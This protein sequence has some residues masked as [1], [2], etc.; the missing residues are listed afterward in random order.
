[1]ETQQVI[2]KEPKK[3]D[4]PAFWQMTIESSLERLIPPGTTADEVIAK[5][6]LD[7]ATDAAEKRGG[8]VNIV[9]DNNTFM[10]SNTGGE[11]TAS[12][13]KKITNFEACLS[14]KY[15]KKSYMRG[16]I[17]HG[18]KIAIMLAGGA[19]VES[20]GWRYTLTIKNRQTHDAKSVLDIQK[21]SIQ[22][23]GTTTF[24]VAIQSDIQSYILKHI[25]LNPH[26]SYF[27][28]DAEYHSV[29]NLNKSPKL[30]ILSYKEDTFNELTNTY[31]N[32]YDLPVFLNMFNLKQSKIAN[33]CKIKQDRFCEN[34]EIY[35]FIENNSKPIIPPVIGLEGITERLNQLSGDVSV[36]NYKKL[37]LD[38]GIVE[39][40][41]LSKP[42]H[43][44][45]INGAAVSSES[46]WLEKQ[47]S[48][49]STFLSLHHALSDFKK[50]T[51]GIYFSLMTT[52]PNFRD[53][54]KQVIQIED[55][56]LYTALSRLIK[57]N[58]SKKSNWLLKEERYKEIAASEGLTEKKLKEERGFNITPVSFLFMYECKRIAEAYREKWG[59]MTKRGLMYQLIKR[60]IIIDS[61]AYDQMLNHVTNG[62]R[63]GFIPP[64]LFEDRSRAVIFPETVSTDIRPED[65][66]QEVIQ[67]ALPPPVIDIWK[68]QEYHVELWIEK[69]ALINI[70]LPICKEK[71]VA[72]FPVRGFISGNNEHILAAE[73]RFIKAVGHEGKFPVIIYAGDLDPS[74]WEMYEKIKERFKERIF[75]KRVRVDRFAITA[76]QAESLIPFSLKMKDSRAKK[77]LKKFPELEGRCYELDAIEPETMQDITRG[78]IDSYFDESLLNEQSIEKWNQEFNAL[79]EKYIPKGETKS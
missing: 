33:F 21:E 61:S 29:C 4:Y 8:K 68:N 50:Y 71:Q 27:L 76:E 36:L 40:A 35:D 26:I 11:I 66:V 41:L 56:K 2:V 72:V 51:G 57:S 79:R 32:H 55:A 9:F 67:K 69:D 58:I 15:L 5:E 34:D 12:D 63:L 31:K 64:N 14:S 13:I 38:E 10:V 18:L 45:G 6:L 3:I 59:C 43:I 20:G 65:Y 22:K 60:G 46:V 53:K 62:E 1:M 28:N 39:M 44:V 78:I 23:N 17:G 48:T 70:F 73:K 75:N 7:N 77:F 74:G 52:S 54:N 16:A 37:K 24:K 49:A 30:D 19:V 25:S 42:Y 47:G